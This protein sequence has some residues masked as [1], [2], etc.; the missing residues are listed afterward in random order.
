MVLVETNPRR[1]CFDMLSNSIA[2]GIVSVEL[3]NR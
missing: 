2:E 1:Y 3:F